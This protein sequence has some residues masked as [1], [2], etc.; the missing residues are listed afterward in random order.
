MNRTESN[1]SDNKNYK[2]IT[3]KCRLDYSDL[4]DYKYEGEA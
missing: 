4:I 1:T 3:S 2:I